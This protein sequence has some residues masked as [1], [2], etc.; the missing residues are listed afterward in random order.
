MPGI[1]SASSNNTDPYWRP[2]ECE[3]TGKGWELKKQI[4]TIKNEMFYE[5]WW[6]WAIY[7]GQ[8]GP[9]A[10]AHYDDSVL[11]VVIKDGVKK[12][13]KGKCTFQYMKSAILADTIT[14]IGE[15]ALQEGSRYLESIMLPNNIQYIKRNAFGDDKKISS[16]NNIKKLYVPKTIKS[17]EPCYFCKNVGTIYFEG[18]KSQWAKVHP[19]HGTNQDTFKLVCNHKHTWSSWKW[20]SKHHSFLNGTYLRKCS[21]CDREEYSEKKPTHTHK[22]SAWKTTKKATAFATGKKERTCS[23]CKKKETTTIAKLKVAKFA[24]TSYTVSINSPVQTT[25]KPSNLA[26]GDKVKSYK[27]S[28]SSIFTVTS[29]GKITPKKVGTAKLTATLASGKKLTTTIK[30]IGGTTYYGAW[31]YPKEP[32][33]HISDKYLDYSTGVK[34]AKCVGNTLVLNAAMIKDSKGGRIYTDDKNKFYNYGTKTFKLTSNTKYYYWDLSGKEYVTR[35]KAVSAMN[36]GCGLAMT[37]KVVN[38]KVTDIYFTS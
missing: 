20:T 12:V 27:S 21:V 18:S 36:S 22:W 5:D 34:S 38:G 13:P 35:Q 17:I 1:V 7:G 6:L 32:V 8:M 37:I 24:K 4:L 31:L 33:V 10:W 23:I 16:G 15:D 11:R 28:N 9:S 30:V 3:G 14:Y 25:V 26:K 19:N 29:T 2:W